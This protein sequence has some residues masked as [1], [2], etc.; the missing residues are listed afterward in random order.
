M[1]AAAPNPLD[2]ASRPRVRRRSLWRMGVLASL[3]VCG[4]LA[5]RYGP[6]LWLHGEYLLLQRAALRHTAPADRVVYEQDP[7]EARVLLGRG[8]LPVFVGNPRYVGL[9]SLA[10]QCGPP[11]SLDAPDANGPPEPPAVAGHRAPAFVALPTLIP[12]ATMFGAGVFLHA[13]RDPAGRQRLVI[14]QAILRE[15][16]LPGRTPE[17][18]VGTYIPAG[19]RPGGR[20]RGSSSWRSV[21][22]F[23]D[24]EDDTPVRLYAGQPDPADPSHFT[25]RYSRAGRGG[26]L[27][28]YLGDDGRVTLEARGD[29]PGRPPPPQR[30]R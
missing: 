13:R 29:A 24:F 18:Y 5:Y 22:P 6:P 15:S 26:T 16:G 30:R 25:I 4:V 28:G 11:E 17:L 3:A 27:H 7:A 10:M 20:I 12:S 19:W 2:Y 23:E 14:V 1:T 21:R 9:R 8:Y